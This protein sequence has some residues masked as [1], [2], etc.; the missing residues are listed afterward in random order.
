[1]SPCQHLLVDFSQNIE[2]CVL[3]SCK[4]VIVMSPNF[5]GSQWCSYEAQITME[6]DI[7]L[8]RRLLVPVMLTQ[9][10]V[11]EFIGRLT[12]MDVNNEHFWARFVGALRDVDGLT[13]LFTVKIYHNCHTNSD[14]SHRLTVSEISK[15]SFNGTRI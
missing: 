6:H 10:A 11:P 7:D 3:T 4:T 14:V 2:R 12:Y 9:C 1:M 8:R 13:S 5:L 15:C